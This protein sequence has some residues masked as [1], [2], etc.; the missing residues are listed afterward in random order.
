MPKKLLPA[1]ALPARIAERL[2]IWGN[3]IR[4]QRLAQ[5]IRADDLCARIGTARS[6][7]RRIENGNSGV[8]VELY[9]HALL[10]LGALDLAAPSLPNAMWEIDHPHSRIRLTAIESDHDF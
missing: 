3:C 4:K 1:A 9:L 6:T 2:Q 5:R 7:L 10:I 8:A